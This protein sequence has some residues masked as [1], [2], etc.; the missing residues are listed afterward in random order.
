M[1]EIVLWGLYESLNAPERTGG[2]TNLRTLKNVAIDSKFAR[3]LANLMQLRSLNIELKTDVDGEVFCASI[4]K[5]KLLRSL[6]ILPI[7]GSFRGEGIIIVSPNEDSSETT[8]LGKTREATNAEGFPK[9][10]YLLLSKL[11]DLREWGEVEKGALPNLHG[12][13][14][15]IY[16]NLKALPEGFQYLSSLQ[17][18]QLD[19]MSDEFV[20]RLKNEDHYKVQHM[21]V[22]RHDYYEVEEGEWKAE[23]L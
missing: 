14:M 7:P 21:P 18:L 11:T 20:N 1:L 16:K 19:F 5:M 22:V 15:F 23:I 10:Q 12:V 6:D 2:L 3:Y 9:L 13:R 4:H 8:S 17:T